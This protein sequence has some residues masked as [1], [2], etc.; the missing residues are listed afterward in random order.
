VSDAP[1]P[2]GGWVPACLIGAF[3]DN[4]DVYCR[5]CVKADREI[6]KRLE[7][8]YDNEF[9]LK[10]IADDDSDQPYTGTREHVQLV[11]VQGIRCMQCEAQI[12]EFPPHLQAMKGLT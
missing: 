10:I 6:Q 1:E 8:P 12:P 2:A 3:G 4:G 9:S 11:E 7:L 5:K